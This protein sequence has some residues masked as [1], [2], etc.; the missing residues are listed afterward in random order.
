MAWK[1]SGIISNAS[2]GDILADTGALA[3]G[4]VGFTLVF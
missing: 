2:T 4:L 1:T 3:I